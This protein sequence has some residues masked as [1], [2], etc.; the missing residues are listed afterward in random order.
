MSTYPASA[1]HE[2]ERRV[3]TR[4]PVVA[5]GRMTWTEATGAARSANVRIENMSELG[6]LVECLS[7]T[8]IRLHRLVSLSLSARDRQRKEL[9]NALRHRDV[10]A[11]V[12]RTETPADPHQ[13]TRR[14]ALRLL[15]A[16]K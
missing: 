13:P 11:A 8:A 10:Q 5:T 1:Q 2:P 3:V 7:T 4:A 6:A 16:P 9:P 12:Y 15:V 14:Y